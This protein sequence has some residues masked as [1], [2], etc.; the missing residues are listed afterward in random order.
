MMAG[1]AGAEGGGL[2]PRSTV[3]QPDYGAGVATRR[4]RHSGAGTGLALGAAL[5]ILVGQF[6][7]IDWWW[8]LVVGAALGLIAGAIADLRAE[9]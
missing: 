9:R 6:L 2:R 5:G 4:Q 7:L 3:G 1:R 8:G